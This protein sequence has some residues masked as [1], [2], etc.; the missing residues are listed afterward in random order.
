[1]SELSNKAEHENVLNEIFS[2]YN[3]NTRNLYLGILKVYSDKGANM[4][5]SKVKEDMLDKI[6]G[7]VT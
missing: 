3:E 2:H 4:A 5:K 6:K 1:M 7:V